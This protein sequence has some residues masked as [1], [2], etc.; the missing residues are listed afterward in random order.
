[1]KIPSTSAGL[2]AFLLLT[3]ISTTWAHSWAEELLVVASNGSMVGAPGYS[4]GFVPRAMPGFNDADMTYLI[5]PNGRPTG[6]QIL[7]TDLMCKGSQKI[8]NQTAGFPALNASPGDMIAIRYQENGHVTNPGVPPGKPA[9]GGTIY[10]YG[11]QNPSDNDTVL[12]IHKVWNAAGTGGNRNGVLLATRN[13][14]DGQCYQVDNAHPLSVQRQK[15]FPHSPD[16]LMGADLWCQ[17]DVTL[18][19]NIS[20]SG[21]Y[22]LYWLWDWPTGTPGIGNGINEIY[23]TCID[24]NVASGPGTSKN[25]SFVKGQDLNRAAI[26]TELSTA[27]NVQVTATGAASTT[28]QSG[29]TQ[30]TTTASGNPGSAHSSGPVAAQPNVAVNVVTTTETIKEI[31]TMYQTIYTASPSSP[32]TTANQTVLTITTDVVA[33]AVVTVSEPTATPRLKIRGRPV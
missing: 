15:E 31:V 24:V 27:F 20:S 3:G 21:S 26:E 14:D 22:T 18:P 11:T 10:I 13:F 32:P 33:V 8:G 25:L 19:S 9:N 23:T 30:S 1:M 12:S 5:P 2:T 28:Q 4:R 6:N 7:S 17:S 16:P 29:V